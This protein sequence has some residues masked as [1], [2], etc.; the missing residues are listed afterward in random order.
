MEPLLLDV[1][2]SIMEPLTL[3]VVDPN[4]ALFTFS[5]IR[6]TAKPAEQP[7][8]RMDIGSYATDR[9]FLAFLDTDWSELTGLEQMLQILIKMKLSMDEMEKDVADLKKKCHNDLEQLK[10]G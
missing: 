10:E 1:A 2:V 7:V 5:N 8:D 4:Q 9:Q 6:N 3:D